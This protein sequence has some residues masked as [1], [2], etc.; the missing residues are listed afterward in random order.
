MSKFNAVCVASVVAF[1]S[2]FGVSLSAQAK[3]GST[4]SVGSGVKCWNGYELQAD[5][6]YKVVRVCGKKG[7]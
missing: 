5:G 4:V 7:V 3:E 1:G 2:L 6:S